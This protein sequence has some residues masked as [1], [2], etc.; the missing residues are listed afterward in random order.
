MK[1]VV[2]Y[3]TLFIFWV[4]IHLLLSSALILILSIDGPYALAIATIIPELFILS[5]GITMFTRRALA[6]RILHEERSY[7]K[8]IP[9]V[10]VTLGGIMIVANIV[11]SAIQQKRID[12]NMPIYTHE[13]IENKT[14]TASDNVGN[15]KES[16]L[17]RTIHNYKEELDKEIEETMKVVPQSIDDVVTLEKVS[18]LESVYSYNYQLK[19]DKANFAQDDLNDI[20]NDFGEDVRIGIYYEAISVCGLAEIDPNEFFKAANIKFKYSFSDINNSHIGTYE[21]DYK[22]LAKE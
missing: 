6:K 4:V 21:L 9:T 12:E 20:I 16:P 11:L 14:V 13:V 5:V 19:I 8:V 18:K 15:S 10:L 22:E 17:T 7:S 3:S 1:N 2:Y